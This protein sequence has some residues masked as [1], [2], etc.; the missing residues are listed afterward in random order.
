VREV[1]LR[2]RVAIVTGASEG[3]GRATVSYFSELGVNTVL[4]ARRIEVI[5][6]FERTLRKKFGTDPLSVQADVAKDFD[7]ERLMKAAINKYGRIDFVVNYAGNPIGYLTR[8]RRKPIYEQ[9]INQLKEIAEVDHF[10]SVRILKYV[11]PYMIGQ[12]F[13]RIILISST[14]SVYGYSEDV[15]YI[16]YKKANEGLVISS[17][18]RSKREGWGVEFFVIAP[19]DVFNPSTWDS[20]DNDEKAETVKY[21]I[22]ESRTVAK[23]ASLILSG[24]LKRKYVMKVDLDRGEVLDKGRFS[25]LKDGDIIV[26]D[27]KTVPKLFNSVGEE[28]IPFVPPGF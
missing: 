23:I 1:G 18:L 17:A 16:P 22:I 2:G 20:Y 12:R 11:L 19:G 4:A 5:E 9:D 27:A 15:N 28:Y 13:G 25:V 6:E 10:G 7:V 21:G 8:D 14:A 26:V 3:M 24:K